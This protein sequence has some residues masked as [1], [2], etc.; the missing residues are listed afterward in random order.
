MAAAG[1]I[2]NLTEIGDKLSTD[3]KRLV[4]FDNRL[5]HA[6]IVAGNIDNYLKKLEDNI[7]NVTDANLDDIS[8]Q[9]P[10]GGAYGI[11][12]KYPEYLDRCE[13]TII[14]LIQYFKYI[15]ISSS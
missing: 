4:S 7:D 3:L 2:D 9:F 1:R 5:C 15:F 6:N 13:C 14:Y 11:L 8:S 12:E 10:R